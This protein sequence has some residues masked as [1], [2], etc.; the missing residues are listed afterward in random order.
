[1][2]TT[3]QS[4]YLTAA[5][6]AKILHCDPQALRRQARKDPTALGF[7]VIVVGR[8]V[9]IPR[10]PFLQYLGAERGAL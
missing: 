1:M 6:A 3:R 5:E 7:A 9:R 8:R 10:E 4:P 2:S